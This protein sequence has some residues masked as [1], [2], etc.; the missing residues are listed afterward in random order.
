M[1]KLVAWLK[2]HHIFHTWSKWVKQDYL[3]RY[4]L[5]GVRIEGGDYR[6]TLQERSFSVC[7]LVQTHNV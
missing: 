5:A 1:A 4:S 6:V 2:K 7:G 3:R